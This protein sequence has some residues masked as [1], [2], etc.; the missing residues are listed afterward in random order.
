[1]TGFSLSRNLAKPSEQYVEELKGWKLLQVSNHHA[2]SGGQILWYWKY[3]GFSFSRD[4]SQ[5]HMIKESS[6]AL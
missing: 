3:N 2:K 1:M 6:I 4:L 5:D